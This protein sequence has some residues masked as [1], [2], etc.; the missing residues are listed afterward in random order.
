MTLGQGFFIS[1]CG[2]LLSILFIAVHEK[3]SGINY[4]A[5]IHEE[6]HKKISMDDLHK[7]KPIAREFAIL[8]VTLFGPILILNQYLEW[9]LLMIISM[10]VVI[11][12]S[13]YFL[14]KHKGRLF[15]LRLLEYVQ[16]GILPKS[17]E[18]GILLA[19]GMLISV[20]HGSGAG[21]W[22][23]GWIFQLSDQ[24]TFINM[25][26]ILP[27]LVIFLGFLGLGPLTVMVQA[28]LMLVLWMI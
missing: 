16:E 8:F 3:M 12:S 22:V 23:I 20:V 19:A 21:K 9:G 15:A 2:I 27:F 10:C 11:W 25:L 1:I 26:W 7:Y 5:D 6:L 17:Q 24:Y 18:M 28:Y 14:V 13:I 4:T